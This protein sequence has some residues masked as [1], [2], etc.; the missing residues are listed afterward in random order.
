MQPVKDYVLLSKIEGHETLKSGLIIL[1]D[2]TDK[3]TPKAL[4]VGT[5]PLV[6]EVKA[7]DRVF[8]NQHAVKTVE[9]DM[10]DYLLINVHDI[11]AIIEQ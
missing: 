1:E 9:N 10:V 5:G 6:T 11:L 4:V 7:G 2:K 3:K 8:Y